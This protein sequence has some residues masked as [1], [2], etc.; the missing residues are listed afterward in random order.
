M[1]ARNGEIER[2]ALLAQT[3]QDSG[4]A[5]AGSTRTSYEVEAATR[6]IQKLE[7]ANLVQKLRRI[8]T[9]FVFGCLALAAVILVYFG[10]MEVPSESG[11]CAT[12]LV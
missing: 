10:G 5:G 6:P 2:V 3:G 7:Q 9:V 11:E 4:R 1:M 12:N 8:L